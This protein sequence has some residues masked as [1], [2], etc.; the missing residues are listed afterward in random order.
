MKAL[1]LV[2]SHYTDDPVFK[3]YK[4]VWDGIANIIQQRNIPIDVYFLYSKSVKNDGSYSVVGNEIITDCENNYWY[5]L[6]QKVYSGFSFFLEKDYDLVIKTNLST[7]VNIKKLHEHLSGLD[8]TSQYIYEGIVGEW[9]GIYFCS[10]ADM[11]L[12]RRAV[13]LVVD[14]SSEMTPEWTDDI[15]IGFILY[16]N[17]HIQPVCKPFERYDI[18]HQDPIHEHKLINGELAPYRFIRVKIRNEDMDC[19]Y[20]KMLRRINIIEYNVSIG[21]LL[22]GKV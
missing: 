19:M 3:V 22:P 9:K 11:T 17:N 13:Q 20:F 10:G 14:A 15:F 7:F 1:L 8:L 4:E 6:L 12:N 16:K 2:M 18:I 21:S 5:A